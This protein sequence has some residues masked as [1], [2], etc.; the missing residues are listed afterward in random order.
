MIIHETYILIPIPTHQLSSEEIM[1]LDDFA[2]PYYERTIVLPKESIPI[3]FLF[4]DRIEEV[5]ATEIST[6]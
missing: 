5:L 4:T 1:P 2:L 6:E 3:G